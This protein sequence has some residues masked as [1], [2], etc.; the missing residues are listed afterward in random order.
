MLS[1]YVCPS[2][3]AI[4]LS[5]FNNIM[6]DKDL[7]LLGNIEVLKYNLIF[8]HLVV[9]HALGIIW[10]RFLPKKKKKDII[11]IV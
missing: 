2:D 9:S 8:V 3:V 4:F 1:F 5:W 11:W 6:D 7:S 10:I